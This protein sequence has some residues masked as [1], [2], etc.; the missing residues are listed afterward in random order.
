LFRTNVKA[1]DLNQV[2]VS[3]YD[4]YGPTCW[5]RNDYIRNIISP[6]LWW[7]GYKN[8][9]IYMPTESGINLDPTIMVNYRS[10]N[11]YELDIRHR[12][13]TTNA[14]YQNRLN[15]M[16]SKLYDYLWLNN[17][18]PSFPSGLQLGMR[19]I[20]YD[21]FTRYYWQ[22]GG[23][24]PQPASQK[25]SEFARLLYWDLYYGKMSR[26][27]AIGELEKVIHNQLGVTYSSLGEVYGDVKSGISVALVVNYIRSDRM[28]QGVQTTQIVLGD[29]TGVGFDHY[30]QAIDVLQSGVPIKIV[31]LL[32]RKLGITQ[33][34]LY[35]AAIQYIAVRM[36]QKLYIRY[37]RTFNAVV[38][39]HPREFSGTINRIEI[40]GLYADDIWAT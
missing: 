15:N 28:W 21:E 11:S 39:V 9:M 20:I 18:P 24:P 23:Y 12:V 30:E 5:L 36:G 14:P 31:P 2:Q 1:L 22:T 3:P 4:L 34:K 16:K 33:D 10:A 37:I 32:L 13:A 29:R 19:Q 8:S 27:D 7:K 38:D 26:N 6:D 25:A 17:C 40:N 35:K